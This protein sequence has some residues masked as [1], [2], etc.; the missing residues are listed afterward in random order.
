M[1][2]NI[3]EHRLAPPTE[4]SVPVFYGLPKIHKPVPFPARPIVSSTNSMTYNVAK[5][6]AGLL[7][8]LVGK[9]LKQMENIQDFVNKIDKVT[10]DQCEAITSCDVCIVHMYPPKD[11]VELVR[12]KL[13]NDPSLGERTTLTVDDICLLL[14]MCL[15]Y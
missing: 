7:A 15:N 1:I 2:T 11:T 14:D 4:P 12:R 5:H 10:L 9:T 13:T 6:I 8:T 3:T